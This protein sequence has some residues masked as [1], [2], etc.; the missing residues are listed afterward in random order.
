MLAHHRGSLRDFFSRRDTAIVIQTRR[1]GTCWTST[2]GGRHDAIR[3]SATVHLSAAPFPRSVAVRSS[4][5]ALN[6][7]YLPP[8]LDS[9]K[10]HSEFSDRKTL[11]AGSKLSEKAV[12]SRSGRP[13]TNQS[14]GE[15]SPSLTAVHTS[16]KGRRPKLGDS[17][18]CMFG[19]LGDSRRSVLTC[20]NTS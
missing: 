5:Q 15:T 20:S 1:R 17:T 14:T 9:F 11:D 12:W 18:G 13:L 10:V 4:K 6:Q 7:P 2:C 16:K 19:G 8:L 3:L